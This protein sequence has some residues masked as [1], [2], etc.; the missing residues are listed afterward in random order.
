MNEKELRD[1]YKFV[2]KY[3]EKANPKRSKGQYLKEQIRSHW[4]DENCNL[5]EYLEENIKQWII[6]EKRNR[7]TP[8]IIAEFL[9][10]E[11]RDKIAKTFIFNIYE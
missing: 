8:K 7:I 9:T 5:Y 1:S 11:E 6:T 10:I 2:K 4:L 3:Y